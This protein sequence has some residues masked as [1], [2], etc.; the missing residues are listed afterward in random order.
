LSAAKQEREEEGGE[1]ESEEEGESSECVS[2]SKVLQRVDNLLDY[3]GQRG[4]KYSDITANRKIHTAVR[5]SLNSLQKQ[6][7]I[8][9]CFSK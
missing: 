1:D 3:M 8:T 7:T 6:A 9:N 4:F 5:R 2:H